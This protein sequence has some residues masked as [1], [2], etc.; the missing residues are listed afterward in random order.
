[1]KIILT[2][3]FVASLC[4]GVSQASQAQTKKIKEVAEK[5]RSGWNYNTHTL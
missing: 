5:A 1:M 2:C 4:L 3:L